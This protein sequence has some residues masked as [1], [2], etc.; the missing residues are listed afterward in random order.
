M[1]DNNVQALPVLNQWL[2]GLGSLGYALTERI[3]ITYVIFFYLP[4]KEYQINDL[5][6]DQVFLGFFTILGVGLLMG[7]IVDGIVDPMIATLSDRTKSRLG[8]RKPF[9]LI[10]A[11]PICITALLIFFPIFPGETSMINGIWAVGL[12]LVF[13]IF[14][15]AYITPYFALISELGHTNDLRINFGTIHAL[16]AILGMVIVMVVFP[17]VVSAF[18]DTGMQIRPSYQWTVGIFTTVALVSLYIA[19]FSFNEKKHCLPA[20]TPTSSMWESMRNVFSIKAFRVFLFGELFMQ[21]SIFMLNLGLVYYV[22]VIF[23][24]EEGFLTVLGG[25]TVGVALISFPI[26]NKLSKRIGKKK[27]IL[28][29]V[30]CMTAACLV[31]FALSWNMTDFSFY[32]GVAMF[33][34]GGLT[35][36]T[37]TI[38]C[39]PV[40]ADLAKEEY[41]RTGV[42]REA[43]F[44]AA[45]NLPVKITI[46][47]AGFVFNYLISAFGR[48]V[49]DPLG[50]QLTLLVM[51]V[52]ALLGFFFFA[53]YP[54]N[55]IQAQ[56]AQYQED[57]PGNDV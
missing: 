45:R 44:Y 27:P 38:L 42:K 53:A 22:V 36:S 56:L 41:L 32:I 1:A 17:A 34:L 6:T 52:C 23:Q 35:L 30:L 5:V 10:S 3:L 33:A 21:F 13:Y 14:F 43:M 24:Q 55:K 25:V 12:W 47:L 15:T 28:F 29:G 51:G 4:P 19:S 20:T 2:W 49:A 54:E 18:Q 11:L 26:V 37:N 39:L 50:V 57:V 48:D 16:F 31:V 8:R 46:A 9:M 7:R 40:Y